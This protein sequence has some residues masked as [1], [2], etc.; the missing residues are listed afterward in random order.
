MHPPNYPENHQ[1]F[2]PPNT[3]GLPSE[4]VHG[5]HAPNGATMAHTQHDRSVSSSN[6]YTAH[7]A[8]ALP[9]QGPSPPTQNSSNVTPVFGADTFRRNASVSPEKGSAD[10]SS[11]PQ[12]ASSLKVH[13]INTAT[14][15]FT[16]EDAVAMSEQARASATIEGVHAPPKSSIHTPKAKESPI[17]APATKPRARSPALTEDPTSPSPA[18]TLKRKLSPSSADFGRKPRKYNFNFDS[19]NSLY[20]RETSKPNT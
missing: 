17:P 6:P 20:K 4:L 11:T 7:A 10:V 2:V 9:P 3:H 13:D 1:N 8:H 14:N 16:L 5:G 15:A 18:P 12:A 19:L